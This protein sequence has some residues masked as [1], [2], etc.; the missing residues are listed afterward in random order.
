M[1]IVKGEKLYVLF[2]VAILCVGLGVTGPAAETDPVWN[3]EATSDILNKNELSKLAEVLPS[4]KVT[5][6]VWPSPEELSAARVTAKA[7]VVS[8][9]LDWIKR[10]VRHD[11]L[12]EKF[13]DRLVPM[14]RWGR[15]TQQVGEN[16]L[17]DVFIARW[18]TNYRVTQVQESHYNVTMTVTDERLAE[19]GRTD[20]KEF[21]EEMA[22]ASLQEHLLPD[23]EVAPILVREKVA[24]SDVEGSRIVLSR[25]LW[26]VPAVVV[27]H[28]EHGGPTWISLKVARE[29]GVTWVEADTD[30][31]FVRFGIVKF[32]KGPGR[33]DPYAERFSDTP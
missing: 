3:D 6:M 13:G 16:P 8:S 27:R 32:P 26:S 31:R 24:G 19:A 11:A 12:P 7:E 17:C 14:K 5:Q 30:G 29:I 10:Y 1:D 25:V 9:S 21:V 22:R 20:H 15:V 33:L 2:V 18:R 4:W 28:E 23:E